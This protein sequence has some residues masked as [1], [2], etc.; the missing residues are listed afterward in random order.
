M[1]RD[2]RSAEREGDLQG[3]LKS[4][5][6]GPTP[7]G[8]THPSIHVGPPATSTAPACTHRA[9]QSRATEPLAAKSL[10]ASGW[11]VAVREAGG[12]RTGARAPRLAGD[13]ALPVLEVGPDLAIEFTGA[14]PG[15]ELHPGL[16]HAGVLREFTG[17]DGVVGLEVFTGEV[18][19]HHVTGLDV[20]DCR[21]GIPPQGRGIVHPGPHQPLVTREVESRL[22]L[23]RLQAFHF[24][25]ALEDLVLQGRVGVAGVEGGIAHDGDLGLATGEVIEGARVEGQAGMLLVESLHLQQGHIPVGVNHH[26]LADHQ[27]RPPALSQFA[28]EVDGRRP[29]GAKY[30]GPLPQADGKRLGDMAVG[31]HELGAH[32]ERRP[33]IGGG[34]VREF[35]PANRAERR[36]QPL[37]DRVVSQVGP[38]GGGRGEAALRDQQGR[39]KARKHNRLKLPQL[40]GR[41]RFPRMQRIQVA[42]GGDRWLNIASPFEHRLQPRRNGLQATPPGGHSPQQDF[43]PVGLGLN[44]QLLGCGHGA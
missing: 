39:A 40:V 43:Q 22:E 42:D 36:F 15:G 31:H 20:D 44:C 28:A 19:C 25:L 26:H 27:Q 8:D 7:Q 41:E 16:N 4:D 30:Q 29:A 17:G 14:G 1:G 2:L 6:P 9:A 10:A 18:Q 33:G 37:A 3:D 35:N 5:R 12:R 13:Q 32:H 21:P 34:R 23:A 11:R 24:V 38:G